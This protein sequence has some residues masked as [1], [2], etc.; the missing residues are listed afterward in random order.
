[1]SQQLE[2]ILVAGRTL[3][4]MSVNSAGFCDAEEASAPLV[5]AQT[6]AL[7]PSLPCTQA[8]QLGRG[9]VQ[10]FSLIGIE[11]RATLLPRG[12]A[13][14]DSPCDHE[15]SQVVRHGSTNEA[16]TTRVAEHLPMSP[17][18]QKLFEV[19]AWL[20]VKSSVLEQYTQRCD[21]P[22]AFWAVLTMA[23]VLNILA[24]MAFA[25][26][27]TA[28]CKVPRRINIVVSWICVAVA[29]EGPVMLHVCGPIR[30]LSYQIHSVFTVMGI[31][32]SLF[33]L[34]YPIALAEEAL[35]Y[36]SR[37]GFLLPAALSVA[38]T[39]ILSLMVVPA[40]ASTRYNF[41]HDVLKAV[42]VTVLR[43]LD[44][45]SD[46]RVA[47]DLLV[48]VRFASQCLELACP[49]IPN[50]APCDT[51]SALDPECTSLKHVKCAIDDRCSLHRNT[52]CAHQC[53]HDQW[54]LTCL[55]GRG[56][57][58]CLYSTGHD[59]GASSGAGGLAPLETNG[60]LLSSLI[61]LIR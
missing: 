40:G 21:R 26:G 37:L 6:P 53:A 11:Q 45:I 47:R 18:D 31:L 56:E 58:T 60:M 3:S 41:Y 1:M 49:L 52:S 28:Y 33:H 57:E 42:V 51:L 5:P 12:S 50:G 61:T 24:Y 43:A 27:W 25:V 32:S 30:L 35:P 15:P 34:Y 20:G 7:S 46:M 9:L 55:D 38:A 13:A 10:M 22:G 4:Q 14:S 44:S 39:S 54:T 8:V 59:S 48:Q 17:L 36:S 16:S 23:F 29:A 2:D 19:A